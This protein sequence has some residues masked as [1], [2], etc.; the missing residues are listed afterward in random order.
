[1]EA[2]PGPLENGVNGMAEKT[3]KKTSTGELRTVTLSKMKQSLG[4]SG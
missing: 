2:R 1:M 4:E 3:T